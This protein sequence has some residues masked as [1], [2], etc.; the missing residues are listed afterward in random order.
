[1]ATQLLHQAYW[2]LKQLHAGN[3]DVNFLI[4]FRCIHNIRPFLNSKT[5]RKEQPTQIIFDEFVQITDI[6]HR[7]YNGLLSELLFMNSSASRPANIYYAIN[8]LA[9]KGHKKY[10]FAG[11][12]SLYLDLD[13]NKGYTKEQRWAQIYYWTKLGFAPSIV[14]DSGNGYH[15][16]WVLKRL[17]SREEGERAIK[18]MVSLAECKEGGNV[19][20]IS[21]VFRL[22]GFLNVKEWYAGHTPPCGIVIP[23]NYAQVESVQRYDPEFFLGFPPSSLQNL[24]KFYNEAAKLAASP[25]DFQTKVQQVLEAARHA[26]AQLAATQL[27]QKIAVENAGEAT[28]KTPTETFIPRL[29]VVPKT[30]EI[31]WGRNSSWMKKYSLKGH[32]GLT[33]GELD[34]LK[35]KLNTDDISASNLD[36]LVIYALVSK[37]Y[38]KQAVRE[39]WQRPENKLY[40]PEKEANNP[41]YFDMSYDKALGYVQARHQQNSINAE[42][43]S[44]IWTD[45]YQTFVKNKIGNSEAIITAEMRL[46]AIYEDKDATKPNARHWYDITAISLDP[47][48]PEGTT[49]YNL[50]LPNEAFNSIQSFKEYTHDL[51]RVVTNNN[52][53]LQRL[54][55]HLTAMYR[56]A[57]VFPFH[58]KV[59]YKKDRFIFPT[60]EITKDKIERRDEE[61]PLLKNLIDKIPLFGNF[62]V[63]FL[64]HEMTIDQMKRFWRSVLEMHL[65]RVVCSIIGGIAM[66]GIAPILEEKLELETFHLPTINIRGTS[67]T[68]KTET[69][70]HITTICGIKRSKNIFS[71]KSSE[72]AISEAIG[73]TNFL[74]I[75][76][77]EFKEDEYN[78]KQ[79][80]NIRQ[81]IRR[82]YSGEGIL[83]G[84]K[85]LSI[86][87]THLHGGIFV[88]GETPVERI[89]DISE[90]TRILSINTDEFQP[91]KNYEKYSQIE[92]IGW[93]ELCPLLYQFILRQN[94]RDMYERFKE[95]RKNILDE[96]ESTFG[97][98]KLRISHNIACVVYGCEIFDEFIKT[99][100]P[101][102]PTLQEVCK[103]YQT[104]I[105]YIREFARESGQSLSTTIEVQENNEKKQKRIVISHNEI[106]ALI[107]CFGDMLE[108][109]D[110]IIRKLEYANV[111][112]YRI[113]PQN[114]CLLLHFGTI[115]NA[116][117]EF[118]LKH[119]MAPLPSTAKF[120][121][122]LQAAEIKKEEWMI[123]RQI[124]A[125][126][127]SGIV[128]KLIKLR[129]SILKKIGIW[130]QQEIPQTTE[131]VADLPEDNDLNQ[132]SEEI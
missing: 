103:P 39:F 15:A 71:T 79:M 63:M 49:T 14:I 99:L 120:R 30:E 88:A 110:E 85:D 129:F 95:I 131:N 111:F 77:D 8:P 122:L 33:Q 61:S 117:D 36:F 44:K 80:S 64:P 105:N 114:D 26:S 65:P 11:F 40:R 41:N 74:P 86:R 1:M 34:E 57:P 3:S 43:D 19:W 25:E 13:G 81:L 18:I 108:S 132:Y 58:S 119:K 89:G 70:A 68:A 67:H 66:S 21:R 92:H 83:K 118:R 2:L 82:M 75:I 20:D 52:A 9:F 84:K 90:S 28:E 38:T 69:L 32:V 93:Y 16:Y 56:N 37:G 59:M 73:A 45:Q 97:G 102:I 104:M 46:N 128:R 4:N 51:F 12:T 54:I 7:W 76:I 23:E 5:G 125:R 17:I 6:K 96:L 109:R 98:E 72:F 87:S 53:H 115:Y 113:I 55:R 48:S 127:Q 121:T 50:F 60:F 116:V 101:E 27:G 100:H 10:N 124:C 29:S 107:K 94:P 62:K 24:Q 130:P 106:M 126:D 112:L 123:S 78:G 47:T 35:M 31:K 42:K 22:P 91:E